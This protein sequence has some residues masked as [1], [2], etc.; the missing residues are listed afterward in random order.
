M[1]PDFRV[2]Q[3]D[4]LLEIS[5]ALTQELDLEKLLARILRISI[6][7]LA[8]QAGLI[9]LKEPSGWHVSAAHGI[10]PAFLSYLEPLLAEEKVGEL[11][12]AELNR[13]LKNLTYTASMGLLNGV[14]IPL[15][16]HGQVIGVIFIFRNY[17]DIFSPNDK[18]LLQS[19]ADQAA[20]AVYNA[21]LYRQVSYEKQRLDALLDSAADG[22]LI[23]NS[24]HTIE[25][26]NTAFERLY[27][28]PRD[29]VQGK[30]HTE[31]IRWAR[32]P[33]GLTLEEAESGGW[34]L[35]TN[36]YLYVEG[37][38]ARNDPPNLPV[39][40]TYAPLLTAEGG[41][42]NVIA[43]V[44]DITKFR[45][46]EEIK[47]TFVSIVSHELKTP[48]ALIKGYVST[49]RREDAA[50]EKAIVQDSLAVIEEEADHLAAMIEDL[51]DASRLQAGGLTPNL[52]DVSLPTLVGRLAERFRTQSRRHTIVVDF[53]EKFPIILADE[54]RLSQLLSNLL[55]NAIKYAPEGEIR[56]SGETR[57]E[58][59]IVTISDQGPGIDAADLP[60]IFDRF[61][62]SEK[63]VR[64]TKGAGLGLFLAK[65][66]VEA[67][68]G[69]IWV[70]PQPGSGARICFS[71]PRK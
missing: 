22:I 53:P 40:I 46:A 31:V 37:D 25:R 1:L 58:Q 5:R 27:G 56:I 63:A 69:R 44:R 70:D 3:R 12:I 62:R 34:P 10:P 67:H 24:D 54:N 45:N 65:A 47:N 35:T 64:K 71:L 8:G 50:W 19:F 38:L 51:L 43:T 32:R 61:Y 60:H 49:L 16:A 36:A 7:M 39:G 30:A 4:Y 48:V 13:M 66:I 9:A 28:Q 57:P 33:D 41:L 52:A 23:L 20:I 18:L 21:Q 17:P 42:R 68:G 26:C 11:N 6:E 15:S 2:R 14:G 29:S 55:S 59:V